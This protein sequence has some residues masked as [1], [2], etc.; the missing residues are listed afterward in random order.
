MKPSFAVPSALGE[1]T[2]AVIQKLA[3]KRIAK[4]VTSCALGCVLLVWTFT[5]ALFET[6]ILG[7]AAD[8][9]LDD[10]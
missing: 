1:F 8:T 5:R 6:A 4:T 10:L 3:M 9:Q 2:R 7:R